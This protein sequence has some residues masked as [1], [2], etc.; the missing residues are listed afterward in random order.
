MSAPTAELAVTEPGVRRRFLAKVDASNGVDA[1]HIWT[2]ARSAHGY[3][4]LSVGGRTVYAHRI[5]LEGR[6]GRALGDGESALH[7]CDNPPC[8]NPGHLYVGD[9]ARNMQDCADRGRIHHQG[10]A[11]GRLPGKTLGRYRTGPEICGTVR[12][13]S[14]H[15]RHGEP[16]CTACRAAIAEYQRARAAKS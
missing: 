9:Q 14:R 2:G 4:H 5:A 12:G 1:C 10:L 7:T 11:L 13:Y 8:V 3:G 6:L 16:T 15:R